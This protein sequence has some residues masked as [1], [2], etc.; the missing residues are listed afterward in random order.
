M[1]DSR[2]F[3]LSGKT[4]NLKQ[5]IFP[6]I[7]L[8]EEKQYGLAVLNFFCFNTVANVTETC[9]ILEIY[10]GRP[11]RGE[12]LTIPKGCYSLES[13]FDVIKEYLAS[14]QK[15]HY[16]VQPL[17]LEYKV[18]PDSGRIMLKGSFEINFGVENSLGK[19]L[20]FSDKVRTQGITDKWITS[21]MPVNIMGYNAICIS[22]PLITNSYLNGEPSTIL[23]TFSPNAPMGYRIESLPNPVIYQ[24][25]RD[26]YISSIEV[27]VVNEQNQLIDFSGEIVTVTL[28]LTEL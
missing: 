4:S 23:H 5:S 9:N 21:D 20:G 2:L 8:S 16:G 13:L 6:P 7:E 22:C 3:I 27:S 1:A 14:I 28:H 10:F 15:K 24:K 26:N 17:D 18:T 25:I 12:I 19:V 11:S